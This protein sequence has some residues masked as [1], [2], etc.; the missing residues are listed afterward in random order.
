M[1]RGAAY[2]ITSA[3][4]AIVIVA[5]VVIITSTPI[6]QTAA[7]SLPVIS[8]LA[9]EPANGNELFVETALTT[10]VVGAACFPLYKPRPRRILDTVS[11]THKRIF[12]S[13]LALATLGYFDYTYRLPRLTL[14]LMTPLLLSLLPAWFVWLRKRPNSSEGKEIIVGDDYE[15]IEQIVSETDISFLGYLCPTSSVKPPTT[16]G[17]VQAGA[18]TDGGSLRGLERLGGLSRIDET[19]VEYNVDTVVLAFSEA[20]RAEFFGVLDACYKHGVEVKVHQAHANT[21]LTATDKTGTL[22]DVDVEPWDAQDYF[23]KRVFDVV[24]AVT[25]LLLLS[26]LIVMI[27]LTI[28]LED[29]GSI[30]YQQERTA[31]FGETFEVYKFRSMIENAEAQTGATISKEDN[32][33]VDP[34]VTR[35]GRILRQTHLDEIPQLW[36]ALR[37]DM[38]VVGPRPERPELDADIR[39]G[40][41]EWQKRWFV[42]PG[43]TGPAQV[44]DVTG[45][46]PEQ[47][48]RY[49]LLYVRQQSLT[50]D[51]KLVLR[52][53]WKVLS[54]ALQTIR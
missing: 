13:V 7:T 31:L 14:I 12:V 1:Q 51:V 52:Q 18:V 40:V 34:R 8:S 9:P 16:G 32:G 43:L 17:S 4:G 6:L 10:A 36:S 20:D 42:K 26:P 50:Y 2:R 38:S 49:D 44:N 5:L 24:F 11:L 28:K 19:I 39:G 27:A 22:V 33:G 29:G 53:V 37:G 45:T 25:G 21:V 41:I 54:D 46:E 48:I 35:V 23:L 3:T 47:K 15:M 30:L